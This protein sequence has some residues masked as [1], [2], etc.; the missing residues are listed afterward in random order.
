MPEHG[1]RVK[2]HRWGAFGF[3]V[4][5]IGIGGPW[6]NRREKETDQ[7]MRVW[8]A[9]RENPPPPLKLPNHDHGVGGGLDEKGIGSY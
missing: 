2:Q 1:A 9:G 6:R 3:L 7:F 5:A 4:T 8:D